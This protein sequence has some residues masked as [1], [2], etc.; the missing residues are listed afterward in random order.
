MVFLLHKF[1][2]CIPII[3]DLSVSHMKL[4]I[5]QNL[6]TQQSSHSKTRSERPWTFTICTD[7]GSHIPFLDLS[8]LTGKIEIK[9]SISKYCWNEMGNIYVS[10]QTQTNFNNHYLDVLSEIAVI[11]TWIFLLD[12][13]LYLWWIWEK[14]M[15][16]VKMR[17]NE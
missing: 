15:E 9:I 14:K 13:S 16:S 4:H 3:H 17:K 7:I 10:V 6:R 1:A 8:I 11:P 5:L 2:T 12:S